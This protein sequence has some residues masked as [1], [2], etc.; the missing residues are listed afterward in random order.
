MY[1]TEQLQDQHLHIDGHQQ[2]QAS[3]LSA[4][5]NPMVLPLEE[6]PAIRTYPVT[7]SNSELDSKL[8]F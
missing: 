6:A 8:N 4:W 2:A 1:N 5:W 7:Q 3:G